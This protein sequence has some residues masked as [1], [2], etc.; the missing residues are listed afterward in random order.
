MAAATFATGFDVGNLVCASSAALVG[1]ALERILHKGAVRDGTDAEV[2]D[3]HGGGR[4]C[5][6]IC[7]ACGSQWNGCMH[8]VDCEGDRPSCIVICLFACQ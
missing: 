1:F 4:S 7:Q 3:C 5:I 6:V 8:L 2:V